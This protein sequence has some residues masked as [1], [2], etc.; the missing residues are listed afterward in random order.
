MTIS[1]SALTPVLE[2]IHRRVAEQ[3]DQIL[4][5]MREICAVPSIMGQ[6]GAVGARVMDEMRRLGFED[7]RYDRMSNVLGRIGHGPKILLYDSHLDTVDV[8]DRALWDWDPFQG[9]VKDG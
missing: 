6:I 7:V 4:R 8:G 5:F 1:E 2:Q 3:R 9:D